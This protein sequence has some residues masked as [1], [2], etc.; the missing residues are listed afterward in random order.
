[1]KRPRMAIAMDAARREIESKTE[2]IDLTPTWA[3]LMPA[4]IAV[5]RNPDAS[6]EAIKTVS[7]ELTRLAQRVDTLNAEI[8]TKLDEV[9]S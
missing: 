3:S 7:E 9:K 8:R 2:T 4:L 1:M 6:A 5:L